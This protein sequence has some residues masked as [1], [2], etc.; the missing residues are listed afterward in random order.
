MSFN[1]LDSKMSRDLMSKISQILHIKYNAH[2]S[3]VKILA[4]DFDVDPRTA[5]NWLEAKR[6]PNLIQFIK[7]SQTISEMR[8]LYLSHC[9]KLDEDSSIFLDAKTEHIE[10]YTIK[11]DGIKLQNQF[12]KIQNLNQRQIWFYGEI[13]TKKRNLKANDIVS[14]Y[15]V[16][17]ATAHRDIKNLTELNLIKFIGS[18]KTG[19]YIIIK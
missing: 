3:S 18:K 2:S 7:I 13:Y 1:K 9:Q 17:A 16:S 6:L 8:D 19:S 4:R 14:K 15:A 10:I 12:E 5:K 11:I